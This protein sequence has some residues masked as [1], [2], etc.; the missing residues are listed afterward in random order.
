MLLTIITSF[1][2]CGG[3]NGDHISK[4]EYVRAGNAICANGNERIAAVARQPSADADA[5]TLATFVRVFV[6]GIRDQLRQLR[7]LGFPTGDRRTLE[8]MFDDAE[9][10]LRRAENDPSTIDG[11]AFDDVNRR[12]TAYGLRVCGS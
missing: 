4:E 2:G 10:I 3:G 5:D 8:S 7:A 1:P 11:H 12:L 9:T 6:P